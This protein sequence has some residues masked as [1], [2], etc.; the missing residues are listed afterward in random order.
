[1][2]TIAH[3]IAGGKSSYF[4]PLVDVHPLI[5]RYLWIALR[6]A[7]HCYAPWFWKRFRARSKLRV[8]KQSLDEQVLQFIVRWPRESQ[9][10]TS[11]YGAG[12][13]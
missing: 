4:S 5:S 10:A 3:L 2:S 13:P 11:L 8:E 7:S 6:M 1:M 12:V 9:P